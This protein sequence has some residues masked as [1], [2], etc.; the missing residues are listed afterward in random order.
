MAQY[1]AERSAIRDQIELTKI[2]LDQVRLEGELLA[3]NNAQYGGMSD[4][5]IQNQAQQE[6]LNAQLLRFQKTLQGIASLLLWNRLLGHLK[7]Y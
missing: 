4:S 1:E 7:E 3:K 5:L 2:R 6:K